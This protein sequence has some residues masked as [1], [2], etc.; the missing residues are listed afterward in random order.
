MSQNVKLMVLSAVHNVGGDRREV[1]EFFCKRMQT[2]RDELGVET[3]IVGSEGELSRTLVEKYGHHYVEFDNR[4]L[5]RKFNAGMEALRSHSP[6]HVMILGSDDIVSSSLFE[7]YIALLQQSD[8]DLMG[9]TDLYFLGLHTKRWGFGVCGYWGNKSTMLGVAR[10]YSSRILDNRNWN[11][12]YDDRNARM[13]AAAM[14]SVKR[15]VNEGNKIS[16]VKFRIKEHGHMVIDIK[17]RGNISSMSN[18]PLTD[19]DYHEL[20]R[21]HL[22]T[23]EAEDIIS[24]CDTKIALHGK[25]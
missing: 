6:S 3:L 13:D 16:T 18:F 12:W 22:P 10:C 17:T 2:V 20:F 24:Y 15:Y 1:C 7:A 19:V 25:R 5:S 9:I 21:E 14:A 8:Y 4:P 11:L 23:T